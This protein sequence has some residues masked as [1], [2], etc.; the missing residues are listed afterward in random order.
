MPGT[1]K[2][3]TITLDPELA[4]SLD[5]LREPAHGGVRIEWTPQMD[6]AL[7]SART[8]PRQVPWLTLTRWWRERGWKGGQHNTL[9]ERLR[10]LTADPCALASPFDNPDTTIVPA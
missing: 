4:S 1:K 2:P 8:G 5:A 9:R 6:A 7:L 10:T 3:K